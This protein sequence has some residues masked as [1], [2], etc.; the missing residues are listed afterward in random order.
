MIPP[1]IATLLADTKE[2]SAKMDQ[3][4]AKMEKLGAVT[5]SSGSKFTSFASKASTAVIGVGLALGAYAVDKA[6]K[7]QEALDA[8]KNQS[9]ATKTQ[10]DALGKSILNIS[11]TTGVATTD[12]TTAALAVYQAGIKGS[13]AT[14]LLDVAAKAAVI[15]NSNAVDTTKALIAVQTL[16]IAKGMAIQALTGK[17]IAGSKEYVGGLSAEANVLQGRVGAALAG[18]GLKMSAIIPIGAE[19]AKAGLQSRAVTSFATGLSKLNLPLNT[20]HTTT[21]GT[22]STLSTYAIALN[23]VG[24]SQQ[25]LA[26]DLRVGNIPGLLMQIKD[27]A[28]ASGTPL[29]TLLHVVFGTGAATSQIL[30]NNLS[31]ISAQT[32]TINQAG[33]GTLQTSFKGALTQ[34]GPQLHL[35][36]ARFNVMFIKIGKHLLPAL[37]DVEKWAID[38]TNYFDKH[39]LVSKIASDAVIGLFAVAVAYKLGKAIG[40]VFNTVKSLFT[41]SALTG[42]TTALEENTAALSRLTGVSGASGAEAGAGGAALGAGGRFGVL[43]AGSAILGLAYAA[44]MATQALNKRS[45]ST[46]WYEHIDPL[47]VIASAVGMAATQLDKVNPLVHHS[48]ARTKPRMNFKFV[49]VIK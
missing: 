33:A 1:A 35:L 3:S 29:Q 49:G 28:A 13:A 43:K 42:N 41:G 2:Y 46:P 19:F 26:A 25:K 30:I 16:H 40:A 6:V 36:E 12:L 48:A 21:K 38:V 9:G 10:V 20:I 11:S 44:T 4:I 24:L 5:D 7:F 27:A 17:L 47:S 23:Q 18:V 45:K 39:P 8:I 34:L 22:Y 15:T 37:A 14:K 32:K 31:K